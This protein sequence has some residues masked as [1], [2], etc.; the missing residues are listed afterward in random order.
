MGIYDNVMRVREGIARAAAA[1]GR[2]KGDITLVAVSKTFGADKI[3]EAV[4]AGALDIGENYVQEFTEKLPQIDKSATLHF[5]GHLQ[6]NKVRH[7]VGKVKYI[8]SCDRMSLA[9]EIERQAEKLGIVQ[10]VLIEVNAGNEA[11]KSGVSIEGA[12]DLIFQLGEL[13]HIRVCGLMAIPPHN[14]DPAASR[15]HFERLYHLFLD[16]RGKKTDNSTNQM[17]I[18]SMGMS[19]DYEEAIRCGSNMVRVGTAIFG[20]RTYTK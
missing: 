14:D 19:G 17:S 12:Q 20:Q 9:G 16:I 6:S 8:Q 11:S 15:L 3:N 5:I 18:L 7:V 1:A 13:P 10:D 2:P 4:A